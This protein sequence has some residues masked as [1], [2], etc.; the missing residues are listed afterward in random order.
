LFRR[1]WSQSHKN[2]VSRLKI[3]ATRHVI[4]SRF[5]CEVGGACYNPAAL[6]FQLLFLQ[7]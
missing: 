4:S 2:E 1:C 5:V 6:A 3:F 7:S